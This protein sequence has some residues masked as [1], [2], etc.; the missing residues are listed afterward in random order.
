MPI[1][2]LQESPSKSRHQ[3]DAGVEA[4]AS[5]MMQKRMPHALG[6]QL[7]LRRSQLILVEKTAT[8]LEEMW[9]PFQRPQRQ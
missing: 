8:A 5:K 7:C 3:S 6:T 9:K 1:P 4:W 2:C